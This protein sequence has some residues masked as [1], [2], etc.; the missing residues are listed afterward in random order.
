M[1]AFAAYFFWWT[2]E[3]VSQPLEI[4]SV[5]FVCAVDATGTTVEPASANKLRFNQAE[6]PLFEVLS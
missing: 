3:M 1:T 4:V 6:Q 2:T 5:V